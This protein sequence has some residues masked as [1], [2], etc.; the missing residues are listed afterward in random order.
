[1]TDADDRHGTSAMERIVAERLR[2]LEQNVAALQ[3]SNA[4]HV[5]SN[6]HLAQAVENLT[7][8]TQALRDTINQGRGA[9]W[10]VV[11]ISGAVG[12]ILTMILSNFAPRH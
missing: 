1:M 12:A 6:L 9:V 4:T 3:I 5:A 8:T 11:A 7:E 10:F 2:S